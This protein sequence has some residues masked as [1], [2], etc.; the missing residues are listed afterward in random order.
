MI[1]RFLSHWNQLLT[2]FSW[3]LGFYQIGINSWFS[4]S[5]G[6]CKICTY[7]VNERSPWDFYGHKQV[8][9]L[10]IYSYLNPLIIYTLSFMFQSQNLW[11]SVWLAIPCTYASPLERHFS[12]D[13]HTRGIYEI[14]T[15]SRSIHWPFHFVKVACRILCINSHLI[16]KGLKRWVFLYFLL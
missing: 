13:R 6:C 7:W 8:T 5:Y 10:K 11:T 3:Y 14:S 9:L 12:V 4:F 15:C 2:Q 16:E 1:F